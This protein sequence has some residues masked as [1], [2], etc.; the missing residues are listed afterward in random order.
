MNLHLLLEKL[1]VRR[2]RT[3]PSEI[4]PLSFKDIEHRMNT[5]ALSLFERHRSKLLNNPPL[6][7]V[8]A[9]WGEAVET[10]TGL[11][12]V[13]KDMHRVLAPLLDELK[14]G[15]SESPIGPNG[16]SGI[17]YLLKGLILYKMA[18]IVQYYLNCKCSGKVMPLETNHLLES[19]EPMGQA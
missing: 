1:R 8:P 6:Y 12:A 18:Y 2:P 11:D 7:L 14:D 19:M 9:V 4:P 13:Q 5:T 15:F 10:S 17:E 3:A 16:S